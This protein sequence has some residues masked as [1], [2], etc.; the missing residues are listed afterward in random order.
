MLLAWYLVIRLTINKTDVV[1]ASTGL[2]FLKLGR[3]KL[4]SKTNLLKMKSLV[5]I[6]RGLYLGE[7]SWQ[8]KR[9]QKAQNML[10]W[11]ND[12]FWW[13]YAKNNDCYWFEATGVE[14][15]S[16]RDELTLNFCSSNEVI[17]S[18]F[19][20]SFCR[21]LVSECN[22]RFLIGNNEKRT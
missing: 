22:F 1:S 20:I 7:R 8:E 12:I 17:M 16:K 11:N 9:K 15:V 10:F 5:S 18:Y 19:M 2:T 14:S 3:C 13:I 6:I 4:L 21:I